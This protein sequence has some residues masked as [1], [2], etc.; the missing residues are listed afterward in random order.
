MFS[1]LDILTQYPNILVVDSVEPGENY[2][3]RKDD[4][5]EDMI[6][7]CGNLTAFLEK[8]DEEFIKSLLCIHP[9][10]TREYVER[11]RDEP[12]LFALA[13]NVHEYLERV[14]NHK[15]AAKVALRLV[16]LVYYKPQEVYNAMRMKLSERGQEFECE[17][18][19]EPPSFVK[20]PEI[21]GR[22]PYLPE[23]SRSLMDLLVSYIHEHA[24][25]ERTKARAMLCNLYHHAISDEFS[26][27][28]D[29]LLTSD[30][31][32]N[33]WRMDRSTKILFNR[34][35]AQL[36]LCAFR[37]GLITEAPRF[38]SK[39]YSCGGSVK[40]LLAQEVSQ[41]WKTSQQ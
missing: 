33:L 20:T 11:L 37:A 24:G 25:D 40:D 4:N 19:V 22:E 41:S 9:D 15:A 27:S 29:L 18:V 26:K 32:D 21:V 23:S 14:G 36:G 1:V 38:L 3:T 7:I 31:Q 39:L 5:K 34:S 12:L 6:R 13:Q 28:R 10:N 17:V 2:K 16:E 35:M 30:L 8:A